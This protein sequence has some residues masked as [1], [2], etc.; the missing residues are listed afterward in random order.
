M[1]KSKIIEL[2]HKVISGKA[3]PFEVEELQQW[4]DSFEA[5]EVQVELRS[6]ES[7][8]QVKERLLQKIKA[9]L[10]LTE[11]NRKIIPL[12]PIKWILISA[13]VLILLLTV[14]LFYILY[15]ERK[16][17]GNLFVHEKSKVNPKPSVI[18][19]STVQEVKPGHSG[20]ILT[21]A[22]GSKIVLDNAANGDLVFQGKDRL[23]KKGG[24]LIYDSLQNNPVNSK[25]QVT[26]YNTITTPVKRQFRIVLSDGTKVW[27][28]AASSINFPVEFPGDER[29]VSITGE[30]YFEV[31]HNE[32]K[33]FKVH[34]T[35]G[36]EIEDI[37]TA[38]DVNSYKDEPQLNATL[39]EGSIKM[40][41]GGRSVIVKKGE[42]TQF[43]KTKGDFEI[44]EADP[45]K[46]L[47]WKNG[48][49]RFNGADISSVMR[50]IS[51]WYGVDVVYEGKMPDN[52]F[53]GTIIRD[54]ELSKVMNI[55]KL[56]GLRFRMENNKIVILP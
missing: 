3:S 32:Q 48:L 55:L 17:A 12:F 11:H 31:V 18:S 56:G 1:D 42:Q 13:A 23:I 21:L 26:A 5:G 39:L 44:S 22:D 50:E 7:R 34:L 52:K 38:F 6:A 53:V 46:A 10:N 27:L 41:K 24:M 9:Q 49:F 14:S 2:S 30:V 4:F 20:A 29:S 35:D 43:N 47:A 8:D 45:L 19:D 15:P 40:I 37:G 36:T 16:G 25:N 33:P 28:N 54:T 51:R